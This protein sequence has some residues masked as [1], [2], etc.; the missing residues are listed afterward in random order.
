MSF[1]RL[2]YDSCAYSKTLQESTDPLEYY[3]Y[4][5]KYESCTNCPDNTNNLEF[6]PRVEAESDLKGQVRVGTRC[7]SLKYPNGKTGQ[8]PFT[9]AI[10][11]QSIY[12]LTP[13]NLPRE[14]SSGLKDMSFYGQDM[15]PINK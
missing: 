1:N 6:G 13:T 12:K 11:C 9:P 2:S 3:L 10:T 4:K 15:C 8:V 7:P 14:Y 5:G